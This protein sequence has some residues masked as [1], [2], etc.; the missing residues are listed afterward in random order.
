MSNHDEYYRIK[1][2]TLVEIAD[3]IR[4][5]EGTT[6]VIQPEKMAERVT[7]IE[8]VGAMQ[9]KSVTP[10]E[11]QQTVT[12]DSGYDGLSQVTVGAIPEE[13]V[14][15]DDADATAEQIL[16]GKTAYVD[17]TKVEGTMANNGSVTATMDG[18]TTASIT[19]PAGYTSGGTVSLTSDIEE[20]LAAI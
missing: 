14:T 19:I 17:G 13:Y 20:A 18:L 9:E 10:T 4:E 3:A 1:A 5:K 15:T 2:E 6:A 16:D 11:N 7:A 8:T 12:P